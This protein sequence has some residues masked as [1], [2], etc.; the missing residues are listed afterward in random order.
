M[1][2]A[3]SVFLNVSD[4]LYFTL[5]YG[6]LFELIAILHQKNSNFKSSK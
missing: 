1:K 6:S 5:H 2:M 4:Y 3:E